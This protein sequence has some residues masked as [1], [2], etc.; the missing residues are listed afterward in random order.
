[1]PEEILRG[2][3]ERDFALGIAEE[4]WRRRAMWEMITIEEVSWYL[5][6]SVMLQVMHLGI[7]RFSVCSPEQKR[8]TRLNWLAVSILPRWV[9][10]R[11]LRSDRPIEFRPPGGDNYILNGRKVFIINACWPMWR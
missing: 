5:W 1:M 9:S 6:P 10:L 2:L 4:W 3:G 8:N 7:N 11:R